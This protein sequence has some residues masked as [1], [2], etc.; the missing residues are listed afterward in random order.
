MG[1]PE[2]FKG[3][4]A[5]GVESPEQRL[6]RATACDCYALGCC[7]LLMLLGESGG[8]RLIAGKREVRLPG[9]H[10]I[11]GILRGAHGQSLISEASSNIF[12]ALT[13]PLPQRAAAHE[14][15]QSEFLVSAIAELEPV[16]QRHAL[17]IGAGES[18]RVT[19]LKLGK[20]QRRATA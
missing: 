10:E 3:N 2:V 7:V 19:G 14:I 9:E 5:W 4:A 8:T 16:V 1:A 18:A 20:T 13:L 15:C 11:P 12:T 6:R 17:R